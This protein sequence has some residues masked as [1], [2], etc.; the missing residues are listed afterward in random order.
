[1][2]NY[3]EIKE[4]ANKLSE[5]TDSAENKEK[6]NLWADLFN[7]KAS[8]PVV[9]M[10][11]YQYVWAKEQGPN[12]ITSNDP[13]TRFLEEQIRYRLWRAETFDDDVPASK[14]L[15]IPYNTILN[16]FST[17][18]NLKNN[19]WGVDVELEKSSSDGSYRVIPPIETEDDLKKIGTPAFEYNKPLCDETIAKAHEIVGDTL[20]IKID[21]EQ[22]HWGPFEFAVWL[23]GMDKLISISMTSPIL[24][25]ISW[26]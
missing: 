22:L 7:L 13:I 2:D 12:Y 11:F 4:L 20:D 8:R 26:T 23:R 16:S 6:C 17:E 25:I 19:V 1:M 15:R 9:N 24:C 14:C 10:Y 3:N 21:F 18:E 5:L